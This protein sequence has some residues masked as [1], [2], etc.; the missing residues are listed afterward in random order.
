MCPPSDD[1][2]ASHGSEYERTSLP[3]VDEI[4]HTKDQGGI[5]RF[6]S[7]PFRQQLQLVLDA[8]GLDRLELLRH[9]N[10]FRRLVRAM[11]PEE[12][13]WTVEQVA[14][15]D[16][17][18]LIAATSAEQLTFLM[19]VQCWHR[20]EIDPVR[21]ATWLRLLAATGERKI[22]NWLRQVDEELL[23]AVL[24][25]HIVL[26]KADEEFAPPEEESRHDVFTLDGVY[27]IHCPDEDL[28]PA[29]K[30]LLLLYRSHEPERFMQIMEE[31]I[32]SPPLEI[33]EQA[34]HWRESRLSER[35]YVE[36]DEALSIYAYVEPEEWADAPSPMRR[37]F[38]E[39][40][41]SPIP[42]RYPILLGDRNTFLTI[43]LRHLNVDHLSPFSAEVVV[44]ANKVQVAD[45]M[46]WGHLES[47][48]RSTL[49]TL[50]YINIALETLSGG[51]ISEGAR[52]LDQLPVERLFRIGY[53]QI[54]DLAERARSMVRGSW[55]AQIPSA[56]E[57]LD[58]PWH[59]VVEGLL[60]PRP[61]YR[62]SE[63]EDPLEDY[64]DFCHQRD[65]QT[66]GQALDMIAYQG[67]LLC[68]HLGLN[69][70]IME[71]IRRAYAFWSHTHR[72]TWSTVFLTAL[73]TYLLERPYVPAPMSPGHVRDVLQIL[74]GR[75]DTPGLD[76]VIKERL[77]HDLY[78]ASHPPDEKESHLLR[79]FMDYAWNRLEEDLGRLDPR[80]PV[81]PRFISA[82][83]IAEGEEATP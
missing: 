16:C 9:S 37:P 69:A 46:E 22:L 2:P 52:L 77:F 39:Q 60:R 78:K 11:P 44:V 55:I 43:C 33:E 27:Y 80:A 24:Q 82:L 4:L 35:G 56:L 66:T 64:R 73:S 42:P 70:Q 6:N 71:N 62:I 47:I 10:R 7:L 26:F 29:L 31:V 74:R 76:P 81:D 30:T 19:D 32:W 50:G 65:I 67:H 48:R 12:L 54:H 61:Q 51:D 34:A 1:T 53:S 14:E 13:L 49:K 8:Q 63:Q 58:T 28:L 20:D 25:R 72:L 3:S 57:L 38:S 75:G 41:E 17:L 59:G 18:P 45:G 36:F 15:Q 21:T 79:A 40:K 68:D 23:V 83:V 5:E